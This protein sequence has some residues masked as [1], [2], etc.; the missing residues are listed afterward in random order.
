MVYACSDGIVRPVVK[1]RDELTAQ[2]AAG[3]P[4]PCE[5]IEEGQVIFD[6]GG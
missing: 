6:A 1:T 5:T 4:F 3:A 2:I